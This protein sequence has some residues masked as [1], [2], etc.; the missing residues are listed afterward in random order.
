MH[1]ILV[2]FFDAGSSHVPDIIPDD[3]PSK[4]F[5]MFF[6]VLSLNVFSFDFDSP[7]TSRHC[8]IRTKSEEK[9]RNDG[10]SGCLFGFGW[11][12]GES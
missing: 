6:T 8:G 2:F 7:T 5:Q 9:K 3:A 1:H 10:T 4:I 11:F 12:L